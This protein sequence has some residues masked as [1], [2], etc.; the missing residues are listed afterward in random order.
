M[1]AAKLLRM[2]ADQLQTLDPV[3]SG[4][5]ISMARLMA[6]KCDAA[7]AQPWMSEKTLPPA[8]DAL[9]KK[10]L[11]WLETEPGSYFPPVKTCPADRSGFSICAM[12][13]KFEA[14]MGLPP[15]KPEGTSPPADDP[16]LIPEHLQGAMQAML[17]ECREKGFVQGPAFPFPPAD[18]P[19]NDNTGEV[20][21]RPGKRAVIVRDDGALPPDEPHKV[22]F[23][24]FI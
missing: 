17:D 18:D 10:S 19:P 7:P 5:L 4:R 20:K 16:T 14:M 6:E 11:S 9:S 22:N 23:R 8:G 21:L 2:L 1:T 12:A 13:E 3:G 24:E 15:S